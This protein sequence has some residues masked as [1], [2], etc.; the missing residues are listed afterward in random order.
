MKLEPV[1][2]LDKIN[3]TTSKKIDDDVMSVNCEIIVIFP[4]Y[5][6]SADIQKPH[7][8][9]MVYK[10]NIFINNNLLSCKN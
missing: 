4:I 9:C 10:I 7:S 5:G 1:I 3:T 6:Q 2:K 8:G